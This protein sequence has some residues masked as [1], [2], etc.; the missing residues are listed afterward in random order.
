MPS[1]VSRRSFVARVA[2][3]AGAA[4]VGFDPGGGHGPWRRS[5]RWSGSHASTGQLVMD[6][7]VLDEVSEDNGRMVSRRPLAVLRP[8]SV[9]DIVR[10]VRYANEHRVQVAMRG[11]GHSSF[12]QAQVEAGVV[13]DSRALRRIGKV[14]AGTVLVDAGATWD[15]VLAATLPKG[16]TPP[17]L[18]DTQGADGGRYAERRRHRQRQPSPR[19]DRG[20]HADDLHDHGRRQG[21]VVLREA[22]TASCSR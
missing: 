1:R 16:L 20:P 6:A 14:G 11:Q 9:D 21:D 5:A 15:E 8:G 4:V 12:G 3:G 7:A 18:P 2:A 17:V 10:M 13:I 19:C 22:E